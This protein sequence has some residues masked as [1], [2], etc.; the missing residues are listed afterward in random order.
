MEPTHA[1]EPDQIQ[2][3]IDT[4]V[5]EAKETSASAP[6]TEAPDIHMSAPTEDMAAADLTPDEQIKTEENK[7]IL[8]EN[9]DKTEFFQESTQKEGADG[10]TET[11][12]NSDTPDTQARE[13]ET[14]ASLSAQTDSIPKKERRIDGVFDF[15]QLFVYMLIAV[16]VL[17]VFIFRH[18]YVTGGSMDMTLADG[19]RLIISSLFYTPKGGDIIVFEKT[20]VHAQPLVKRIIATGGE[21]VLM[22]SDTEV[23][24]NG[25]P[26]EGGYIDGVSSYDYPIRCTVPEGCVY[27]LGDHRNN[28][29]DSRDFG[30]IPAE[31]ILGKVL[32]RIYPLDAFGVPKALDED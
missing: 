24:V 4:S 31:Y 15:V 23:Y 1:Y 25:Q 14:A 20:D 19:D 2:L 12:V 28:S 26:V 27:V 21:E 16:V 17:N 13:V 29:K 11:L 3:S 32:L 30:P 9:E 10:I 18:A 8:S 6:H 22:L 5:T 7:D